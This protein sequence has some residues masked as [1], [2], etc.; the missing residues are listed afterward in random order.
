MVQ[1]TKVE[2][3]AMKNK[4]KG[5]STNFSSYISVIRQILSEQVVP[6]VWTLGQAQSASPGNLLE[7]QMLRSHPRSPVKSLAKL[8]PDNAALAFIF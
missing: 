8:L 2:V 3:K 4:E 6:K 1:L 7:K 5:R